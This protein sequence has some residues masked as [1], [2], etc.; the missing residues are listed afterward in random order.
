MEKKAQPAARLPYDVQTVAEAFEYLAKAGALD[1]FLKECAEK[2]LVMR[3]SSE[4]RDVAI[5]H[6]RG[7]TK[8]KGMKTMTTSGGDCPICP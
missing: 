4:L 5:S 7:G 2:R 1:A 3:V 8:T 6:M